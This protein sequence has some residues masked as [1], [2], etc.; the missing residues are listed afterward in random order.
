MRR[1]VLN[2]T[3]TVEPRFLVGGES[4]PITDRADVLECT[5]EA[6]PVTT[7]NPY[8]LAIGDATVAVQLVHD[9]AAGMIA[10]LSVPRAQVQRRRGLENAQSITEWPLRMVPL[11]DEGNDPWTLTL[12]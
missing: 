5:V 10:T 3:N 9:I 7:L 12:T 2:L 6:V 8:A 11:A 4:I 1:C